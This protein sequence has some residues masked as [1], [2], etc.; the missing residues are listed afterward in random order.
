M[1]ELIR[2]GED[3]SRRNGNMT[4]RTSDRVSGA[5][6][7]ATMRA[8]TPAIAIAIVAA[9]DGQTRFTID[10]QAPFV[11]STPVRR[12]R[13]WIRQHHPGPRHSAATTVGQGTLPHRELGVLVSFETK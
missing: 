3:R 9:Q 12:R 8:R 13:A 10:G 4:T 5:Y 1:V 11:A 7:D 6:H 2:V